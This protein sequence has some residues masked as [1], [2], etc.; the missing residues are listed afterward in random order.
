MLENM[1]GHRAGLGSFKQ[2]KSNPMKTTHLKNRLISDCLSFELGLVRI[3]SAWCCDSSF[4][5]FNSAFLFLGFK[6]V[7]FNYK[8]QKPQS[9]LNKK[10]I[11]KKERKPQMH[12]QTIFQKS[13]L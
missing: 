7:V 4:K 3:T 9:H 8:I 5:L 11:Q 12:T 2:K 1:G 10:K 6:P 13:K